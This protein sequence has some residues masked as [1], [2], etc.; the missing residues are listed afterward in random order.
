M[1]KTPLHTFHIPVMGLAYTIDSPIRVAQYGI[2]SVISIADD[3]LIEKMRNFYSTKFNLPY[4]EISQ[5]F[6]NYRAERITSY[7][8]LVDKIVK[9]KFENFK[10]E[11]AESKTAAENF[12]SMLPNTSDIKKGFQSLLEDGISFKENIRNYMESHLTVGEIDVNIMTK[13]DKDNFIK[14]ELLPLEFNDA[15]AA[16][17]GFANSNLES[18]VVLSAGMNPRLYSYFENFSDF[19]PNEKNQLKKKIILKVSDFRSAMIQGNFLAK[20]GLWV[21]EY[22]I[23]SGLNCGGHAFATDGLLLG[24]ILEEFKEKKEQ[25]VQSAH[26]LM[27]KALQQKGTSFPDQP[28]NLKITVQ[29]GVGTAEEHEFLLNSYNVDSVGWGTPFLLVPEATS[30]DQT[31]RNLLIKAKERDLYLSHISP[32]GVPFNTLHG[33]TNEIL[34]QKRI[35]ENKAGSSCPKKFLALSKEYDAH[36]ICT[37]SK[38]YQDIKLAELENIKETL[39]VDVFEKSKI[40]ITEK[41]CLCVGLANSSYLE[42]DIKIKGQ[43][44]GVVICPGPNMAYFDQEVSLKDMLQHIYGNKSVLRAKNRPN[45]FVKELKMYVDYFRTE[46][47]TISGEITANQIKKLNSFKSNLLEGIEYY[48]NLFES[49]FYF[50]S[51]TEKIKY[52]IDFYKME[53]SSIKI[54]VPEM[55]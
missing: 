8:N 10:T 35:H 21:S 40:K 16:L 14:N 52:Q 28:L 5:K 55:I 9:Q 38:K 3:D 42:N 19:F 1:K 46:I 12:M 29:G 48:H 54:P 24:T 32:L 47:E 31:T 26:E 33:T 18:S 4:E 2:S 23:E 25:L 30:V 34:K 45:L 17:R 37:A 49:T 6:H 15:H 53:L 7:L 20:K 43:A 11:L 36:G 41:S 51:E 27:V 44:Q 50:K 39:S 22:R 13:L